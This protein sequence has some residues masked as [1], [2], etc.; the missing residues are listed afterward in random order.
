LN[1]TQTRGALVF[2]RQCRSIRRDILSKHKARRML[3][4]NGKNLQHW[5][6]DFVEH[7]RTVHFSLVAVCV[8]LIG[9]LQFE[10]PK[11]VTTARYQLGEIKYAV[12]N[13]GSDEVKGAVRDASSEAGG[14]WHPPSDGPRPWII[15]AGVSFF[16]SDET[17]VLMPANGKS[18]GKSMSQGE[19]ADSLSKPTSL[20]AFCGFWDLLYQQP[21]LIIPDQSHMTDTLA[22]VNKGGLATAVKYT[23]EENQPFVIGTVAL[24]PGQ[25]RVVVVSPLDAGGQTVLASLHL[26]ASSYAYSWD[27]A[28]DHVI[29]PVAASEKRMD[30]Q[31]ALIKTHPYWKPGPCA[32]SFAEVFSATAG[33]QDKSFEALATSLE[34]EAAKPKAESFE[35]FGVKFPVESASKWGIVLI[36]GIQLYLWIHLHELTPRLKQGDPGWDVAWIGVYTSLPARWLF[37]G[38]TAVLPFFAIVLLG[39]HALANASLSSW[40]IYAIA[41]LS[42]VILSVMIT[43]WSPRRAGTDPLHRK[44][45]KTSLQGVSENSTPAVVSESAASGTEPDS[46]GR[47]LQ[48]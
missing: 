9:L 48:M 6:A 40:M 1:S 23:V 33:S 2:K 44:Y 35:I 43:R 42:S 17:A 10:K 32:V 14:G 46:G 8:A 18:H 34:Q 3:S 36:V 47:N 13:W 30:G 31:A 19:F 26:P 39:R 4:R 45:R 37:F 24:S 16:L 29:A 21:K 22:V 27:I 25:G 28:D 7:I 20:T 38:L 11:D 15:V 41:M 12:D 5:S